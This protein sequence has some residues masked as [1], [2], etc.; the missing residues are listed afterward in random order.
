MY[1]VRILKYIYTVIL[2]ELH[3]DSKSFPLI[4]SQ[5]PLTKKNSSVFPT[6]V[7]SKNVKQ[8]ALFHSM[9]LGRGYRPRK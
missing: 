7:F 2:S 8:L 9:I 4:V 3:L 6:V 1:D 5:H